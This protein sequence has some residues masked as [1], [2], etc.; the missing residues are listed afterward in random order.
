MRPLL[1]LYAA[2]AALL[3]IIAAHAALTGAP[4][5]L[6]TRDP[7]AIHEANPLLGAISN[8]GIVLWAAAASVALFTSRQLARAE[9]ARS[10]SAFLLAAGLLSCWLLLDDLYMLH[11][12][13]LPDWIGVPQPLVFGVY[14]IAMTV[15]I[16]RFRG[17]IRTT[18]PRP[19]AM[20]LGF[21]ALSAAIDQGPAAWH[22]WDALVLVEDGAKLFGLVSWVAYFG[23]VSAQALRRRVTTRA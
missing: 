11:E 2:T 10:M 12:R 15:L 3:G 17:V 16:A 8:L 1:W 5:Y 13:V 22:G 21:F 7:A 14:A 20:A 9:E 23:A 18:D 6:F 19:L 4:P